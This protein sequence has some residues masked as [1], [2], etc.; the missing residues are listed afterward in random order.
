MRPHKFL[1]CIILLVT[2]IGCSKK[3]KDS[4]NEPSPELGAVGNSWTVRVLG[5]TDIH[6]ELTAR[7]GNVCTVEVTWAKMVTKT[8]KFALTE[9]EV[10]DYVYSKGDTGQ[11]FTMV[12]FDAKIGDTYSAT[13]DGVVHTREVIEKNTYNIPALGKDLETIG[14]LEYIPPEVN[15][16][17]F[18]FTIRQIIWY[19]HPVYGLVCVDVYTDQGEYFHVVFVSID[20]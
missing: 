7:E 6:A 16:T 14:V 11:P 2:A 17:Y 10:T 5:T 4:P 12:R 19:W 20:L 1:I 18:G 8:V 13:I 15:S 9:N 3:S